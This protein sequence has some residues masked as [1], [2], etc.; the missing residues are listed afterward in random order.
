MA[1][2]RLAQV[3]AVGGGCDLISHTLTSYTTRAV[4]DTYF[5]SNITLSFKQTIRGRLQVVQGALERFTLVCVVLL[6]A[7]IEDEV[8]A[9]NLKFPHLKQH[10]QGLL[11]SIHSDFVALLFHNL[12]ILTHSCKY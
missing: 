7:A 5:R 4:K 6:Q 9:F 2:S 8:S 10:L 11:K 12:Y 3:Q 1:S